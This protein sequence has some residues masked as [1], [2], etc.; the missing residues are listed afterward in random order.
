LDDFSSELDKE[1]RSFLLEFL[2]EKD[3]QVFVTT[4][5]ESVVV[6]KQHWVVAG[7]LRK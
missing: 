6:G 1:R 7:N 5:D 3:L 4:T 2:M